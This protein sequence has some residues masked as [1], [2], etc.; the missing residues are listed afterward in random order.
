MFTVTDTFTVIVKR[1]DSE[2]GYS[3]DLVTFKPGVSVFTGLYYSGVVFRLWFK[4]IVAGGV[5]GYY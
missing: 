3:R 2:K 4:D 1:S 5:T